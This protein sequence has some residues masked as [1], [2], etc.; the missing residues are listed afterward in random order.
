MKKITG[1]YQITNTIN[2]KIYIGLSK[3]CIRRWY[4]HRSK[5][6]NS[7]KQDDLD[8]PLYKAMKKYGLENFTFTILEECQEKDLPIK[9]IFW[10]EKFNSYNNGYNAT[11]GGDIIPLE[12][13]THI[14]E[15]HGMAKLTAEEV[16]YCRQCYAKGLRSRDIWEDKFKDKIQFN[17]FQRMWHG[18]TWKHVLPEVFETRQNTRKKVNEKLIQEILEYKN[19]HSD[20]SIN[21]IARYFQGKVG[22]GTV[23]NICRTNGKETYSSRKNK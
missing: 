18:Y 6:L 1:I 22:Y 19:T 8:K 3:N 11:L 17:G 13:S 7:N 10:I 15:E 9:E 12:Y 16:V 14:G 20:L 23:Y 21:S 2:G 4:D 5:S